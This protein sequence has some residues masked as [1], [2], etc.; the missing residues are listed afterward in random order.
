MSVYTKETRLPY[1]YHSNMHKTAARQQRINDAAAGNLLGQDRC[2]PCSLV[3]NAHGRP[4]APPGYCNASGAY[5]PNGTERL[6][7]LYAREELYTDNVVAP[8]SAQPALPLVDPVQNNRIDQ[9]NARDDTITRRDILLQDQAKYVEQLRANKNSAVNQIML[10]NAALLNNNSSVSAT[11]AE[12]NKYQQEYKKGNE[13]A[14]AHVD[15]LQQSIRGYKDTSQQSINVAKS[16]N[17][18]E[19]Q[20]RAFFSVE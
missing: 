14:Y 3:S 16:M 20:R 5:L 15:A 12:T 19:A 6:R 17:R 4:V 13:E 2:A 18:R 1:Q 7:Q 9:I 10:K 11:A 8:E